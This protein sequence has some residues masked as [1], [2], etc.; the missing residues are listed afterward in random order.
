MPERYALLQLRIL[1]NGMFITSLGL[2]ISY[3]DT[4]ATALVMLCKL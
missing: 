2:H 3:S 1:S 4:S